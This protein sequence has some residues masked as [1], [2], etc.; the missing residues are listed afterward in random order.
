MSMLNPT[1]APVETKVVA[2][3][4]YGALSVF[5]TWILSTYVFRGHIPADLTNL[6]PG[7]VGTT[8][9]TVAAW[10]ARHTPRQSA[11]PANAADV[12]ALI[13]D[14]RHLLSRTTPIPPRPA[15]APSGTWN[16]QPPPSPNVT[17]PAQQSPAQPPPATGPMPVI[18]DQ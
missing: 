13:W 10:L 7:L 8:V 4:G 16:I 18:K 14:V 15:P 11:A 3:A 12:Q 9:G 2:G 17:A 1:G 6:L 5:V